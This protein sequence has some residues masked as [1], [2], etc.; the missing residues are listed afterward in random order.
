VKN[1]IPKTLRFFGRRAFALTFA[2]LLV[3]PVGLFAQR[4]TQT[5]L[6]GSS[7]GIAPKTDPN[8]VNPWGLARPSA[9]P[10]WVADNGTGKSTLYDGDGNIRSLVVTIPQSP[11]AG[12]VGSPTGIVFNGSSDFALAPGKPAVFLFVAQDGS[13]SGW[14]PQVNPTVAIT[15]VLGSSK[16][17]FTGATVAQNG[18]HRFLYVADFRAGKVVVYDTNFQRRWLHPLAF[19]PFFVRRGFAPFNIQN[20]GGNLYVAY[21][22]QDEEKEDEV[23][24]P[25][26]GFVNVYTPRGFFI[27]RLEHGN[28]FNAPWGLVSAPSDFGS[29]SHKILVGQFGSGEILAFNAVTGRF[30]GKLR[31]ENNQVIEIEGL[32][33]ISFGDGNL[34]GPANALFFAAGIDDEQAGLFGKLTPLQAD[35]T[36]G[37]GQ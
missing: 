20:I 18:S 2:C 27:Q 15:K 25:G 28:W 35:L 3:W 7:L 36:Q 9:G 34:S 11:P 31:N 23:A 32:W 33:G 22:K 17:I 12:A 6:V 10:W 37:S 24:G 26:L 1:Q 4:Y 19:F 5:D 13:V 21:A 30:E 29:F 14:N 16:S 8:L